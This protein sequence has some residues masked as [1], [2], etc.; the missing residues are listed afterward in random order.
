MNNNTVTGPFAYETK[1][2]DVSKLLQN[3]EWSNSAERRKPRLERC[4]LLISSN[5]SDKDSCLSPEVC[6][7][8][9]SLLLKTPSV[10]ELQS[11]LWWFYTALIFTASG[12]GEELLK[13][14]KSSQ[15]ILKIAQIKVWGFSLREV[16]CY[17][18]NH[19]GLVYANIWSQQTDKIL[20]DY[21]HGAKSLHTLS[22]TALNVLSLRFFNTPHE[23]PFSSAYVN[24]GKCI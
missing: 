8:T 5:L 24:S 21:A 2:K 12:E 15:F 22:S 19:T 13:N 1:H 23:P 16:F 6:P 9:W 3:Q 20:R 11:P 18:Y 14:P 7:W 10:S 17:L 4:K